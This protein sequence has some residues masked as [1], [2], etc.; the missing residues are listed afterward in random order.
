[1]TQVF[2]QDLKRRYDEMVQ[3]YETMLLGLNSKIT[4]YKLKEQKLI[5]KAKNLEATTINL[6]GMLSYVREEAN[7]LFIAL[8][9]ILLLYDKYSSLNIKT[10]L[11]AL[12]SR[13]QNSFS[14]SR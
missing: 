11:F 12:V 6:N 1:M 14:R 9:K 4:S 10:R 5:C 3:K 7:Q 13:N 8:S 2:D